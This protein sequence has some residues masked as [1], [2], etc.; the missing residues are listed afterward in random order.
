MGVKMKFLVTFNTWCKDAEKRNLF[1]IAFQTSIKHS[2]FGKSSTLKMKIVGKYDGSKTI[3]I[4]NSQARLNELRLLKIWGNCQTSNFGSIP[5]HVKVK[6]TLEGGLCISILFNHLPSQ[7][8]YLLPAKQSLSG[9]DKS[10]G[11]KFNLWVD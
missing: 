11:I 1:C 4:W 3:N 2:V 10:S 8:T 9:S 7:N 6:T 5:V